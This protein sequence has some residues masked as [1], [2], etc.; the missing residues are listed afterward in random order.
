MMGFFCVQ[1]L[2]LSIL[3]EVGIA[4]DNPFPS[5]LHALIPA[6]QMIWRQSLHATVIMWQSMG[7][8]FVNYRLLKK[9]T[10][11]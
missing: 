9:K 5:T 10:D 8:L 6:V 11:F 1:G 3:G 2:V 7:Y 4:A